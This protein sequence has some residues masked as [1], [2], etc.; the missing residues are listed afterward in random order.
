LAANDSDSWVWWQWVGG[1]RAVILHATKEHL[2]LTLIAVVIG[3][4]ISMPLAF[5]ARRWRWLQA[6][7]LAAT[8]VFYTIP[9]LA[10]LGLLLPLTG[11]TA[12]TAEIALVS[13]TLLILVRN[14]L[15]G[16]DGVPAEIK[17]VAVAMGYSRRRQLLRVELPLA[18]P[19]IVAGVRIAT[20]TTIGLV[21]V[22]A[23]IGLGGLGQLIYD[24]LL[25][26]FRTPLVVGSVLSVA[27]AVAADVGLAG[28]QRLITPWTA[29]V[30][31]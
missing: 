23:L 27:L 31:R 19:A 6:P 10:A 13:Y 20:V 21:T 30:D 28:L 9:S 11:L 7:I 4:A 17:E 3:F 24:G 14:I 26:N 5:A 22:T 25:R 8:G 29:R 18:L 2:V 12:T 16:L 15:I 1:H